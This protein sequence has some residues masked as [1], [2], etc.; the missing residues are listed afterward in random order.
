M[1][2]LVKKAVKKCLNIL[3]QLFITL[4]FWGGL[5]VSATMQKTMEE[6]DFSAPFHYLHEPLPSFRR[7][8]TLETTVGRGNTGVTGEGRFLDSSSLTS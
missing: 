7:C 1:L 2:L 3:S 4:I 5:P 6:G 8:P